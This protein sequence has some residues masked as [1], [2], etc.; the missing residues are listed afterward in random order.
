MSQLGLVSLLKR[1]PPD[2][3]VLDVGCLGFR[4]VDISA[5]VGRRD[6]RHYGIDY[7]A[8]ERLPPGFTF[9]ICDLN[10]ERVP[11]P[12]D[13]FDFTVASHVIEHISEPIRFF[14]EL[15]RVTKPG[16]TIYVEAPSERSLLMPGM[17]FAYSDFRTISFF[18]DP[19]HLGRPW[20]PQAL[21]R[22]ARC[23]SCEP[24]EVGYLT[25]WKARLKAPA[26]IILGRILGRADWYESGM[27]DLVGWPSFMVARKPADARG[28]P[29]FHYAYR[30]DRSPRYQ[31]A[32]L[33]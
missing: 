31:P 6:L 27:W 23:Y 33:F 28:C 3:A 12:S 19:T 15:I 9:S 7:S 11:F 1:C 29:E 20:P 30:P 22:L 24:E 32:Q 8:P 18:D 4:L 21:Y 17:S 2:G 14:S 13:S 5:G 26:K 16:G 25:S 10:A